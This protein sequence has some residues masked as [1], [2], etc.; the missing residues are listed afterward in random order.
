MAVESEQSRQPAGMQEDDR[1]AR[2]HL[3]LPK[4]IDQT[5]EGLAGVNGTEQDSL[6]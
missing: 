6:V 3:S 5:G 4:Q 2:S 1:L